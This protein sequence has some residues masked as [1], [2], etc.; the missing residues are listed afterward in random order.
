MNT[1]V[2]ERIAARLAELTK[3]LTTVQEHFALAQS[4]AD[5][6]AK[7]RRGLDDLRADLQSK[8]AAYAAIG[9]CD[10]DVAWRDWLTAWRPTISA[11]LLQI[12]TPIR[13]RALVAL[14]R[15]LTLS[16][17][18]IDSGLGVLTLGC[19]TLAPLRIGELMAAAGYDVAVPGLHGPN[20]WRGSTRQVEQRIKEH[21]HNH[22]AAK[23]ALE[24]ALLD[25]DS[26]AARDAEDASLREALKS[27]RLRSSAD[28]SVPGVVAYTLDGDLLDAADMTPLQRRAF[29]RAN[30]AYAT[31][32]TESVQAT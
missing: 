12:K 15:N 26:R 19:V 4:T 11:E 7:Q 5:M 20:G 10:P 17:R 29:E 3:Q 13:D 21:T 1:S 2:D 14:E 31:R 6:Y 22:A 24:E 23:A 27:M 9:S 25:D 16:I 30:A 18:L 28:T 8:A 32:S